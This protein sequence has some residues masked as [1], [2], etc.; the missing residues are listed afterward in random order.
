MKI[1]KKVAI[2]LGALL[3][4]IPLVIAGIHIYSTSDMCGNEVYSQAL[5]PHEKYKAVVFQRDCGATTGF[6]TQISIV[7]SS[8][9]LKNESGNIYI[10]DGHPKDVSPILTWP[11]STELKIEKNLSGAEYKAESDW[12]FLNKITIT[13]GADSS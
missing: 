8:D 4:L 1:W 10:I 2:S 5:S 9:E 12:G 11:S 7:G 3:L 13:Y 6:S